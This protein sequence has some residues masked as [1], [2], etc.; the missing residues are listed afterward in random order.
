MHRRLQQPKPHQE[1]L[2]GEDNRAKAIAFVTS[3]SPRLR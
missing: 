1:S 3:P 2:M